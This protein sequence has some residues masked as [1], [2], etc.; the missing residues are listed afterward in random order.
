M[1]DAPESKQA[2]ADLEREIRAERKFTLAEAIGRLA[3]PGA[4]KGA[5]PVTALAQAE[6]AI[7]NHLRDHLPDAGGVLGGV[8]L[9]HLRGSDR[10]LAAVDRPLAALAGGV[11]QVLGSEYLLGELV[12]AADVEWGRVMGER[13]RFETPGRPPDPDDPYTAASVRA[14]LT[15]LLDTIP[16]QGGGGAAA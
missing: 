2:A 10:L 1:S 4:M 3:G 8:V 12:R 15:R 14:A 7:E 16:D 6:A 5:S 11:R 9:R 13:P